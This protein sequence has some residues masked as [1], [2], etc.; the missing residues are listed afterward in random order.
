MAA[1]DMG[2]KARKGKV[3]G[4]CLGTSLSDEEMI[5]TLASHLGKDLEYIVVNY[6]RTRML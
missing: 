3:K 5:H 2:Q 6:T 4:N 1:M